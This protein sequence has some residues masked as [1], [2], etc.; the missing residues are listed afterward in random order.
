MVLMVRSFR[1]T[2]NLVQCISF[3]FIIVLSMFAVYCVDA[4]TNDVGFYQKRH[5]LIE[6]QK[7]KENIPSA[8]NQLLP[9]NLVLVSTLDGSIRGVDRFEGN[10]YW[11]L[12]GGPGSSLIKSN[13]HFETHK[14]YKQG[15][16]SDQAKDTASSQQSS[17]VE[18]EDEEDRYKLFVDTLQD[19]DTEDESDSAD[20]DMDQFNL[21]QYP[22]ED[23][24][25]GDNEEA[26]MYYIIEP[27]DG[28]GLYLYG[29]GRPLEVN[30]KPWLCYNIDSYFS[31]LEIAFFCE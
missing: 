12:K 6:G 31:L 1:S 21:E 2:K 24:E 18:E 26:D 3:F 20:D 23:S 10:V 28:G 14:L 30:R 9:T 22:W 4:K 15:P 7:D 13:S 16:N 8:R 29:D 5:L 17:K 11:T 25:D 19:I 27:Q